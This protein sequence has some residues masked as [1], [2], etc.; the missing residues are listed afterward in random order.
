MTTTLI[1]EL[2]T[3]ATM[4]PEEC[5][6]LVSPEDLRPTS[7]TFM[8][9]I[10]LD[11]A[12]NAA[13]VTS[14]FDA[15]TPPSS[16]LHIIRDRSTAEKMAEAPPS[17]PFFL[18]SSNLDNTTKNRL[19]PQRIARDR[20]MAEK[21]AEAPPSPQNKKCRVAGPSTV[22]KVSNNLKP[23]AKKEVDTTLRHERRRQ[24]QGH[25]LQA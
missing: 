21:M 7:R 11:A 9:H 5:I 1:R 2:K 22:Y 14:L 19:Q 17:H 4:T 23:R 13:A 10:V 8:R 24:W 12:C 3:P 6:D 20:S 15:D 25:L 16:N 18:L